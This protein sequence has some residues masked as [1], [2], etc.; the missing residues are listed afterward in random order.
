MS[1]LQDSAAKVE[2]WITERERSDTNPVD[3]RRKT[4]QGELKSPKFVKFH[5]LDS[6]EGC[7]EIFWEDPR[8]FIPRRGRNDWIDSWGI[9]PHDRR[10]AR[11]VDGM[12]IFE[13]THV[14]QLIYRDEDKL[15]L[16]E[17]QFINVLIDKKVSQLKQA[18]L[19]DLPQ[20]DYTLY[21]SLPFIDDPHDNKVDRYWRRVR[22]SGGLPLS[23]FADKIITPLWGWMRNLHA[24][25]F[26]DFKDGALFGPKDCN[27]VDMMHLDKSGYK[28]IPEDE[29]SIAYILRSPGDVMGYHYD[30]GDNWFV[31]IKLEEIASKEDSTGAVVV[32][33]GAGGIPPDGEQT[34]TFS[35]AH[36]LQQASRSPAG[37]RKAVEVLFGTANYAK[38]LPPS[39]ALTYDFDAF[40]LDGTRRAVREALD[41][42]A[43]LPYASKK[44]VTPLGDRTLESMLDDEAVLS[45]LGMSLKDLKKGVALAQTPLSGSSRTFMEEG[46]SISR[47]DNPGNTACA[48]CGSPKDLKA[49]AAC[50]QRYYCGKEC[51]R[52]HWKEGHKRECK[53]AKRK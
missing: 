31:D 35:W 2:A 30:F 28:Y 1:F 48:Y 9:Y 21:I 23:V 22:V 6:G 8:D 34:G 43:S 42:K 24:H 17:I 18:D 47:K 5:M 7:D 19:G 4:P 41:S 46:V 13:R 3:P 44:F 14:T 51:Q 20:R 29:Y 39:N 33:D 26:H 12:R 40:D 32:L 11:D 16:P 45:R 10:G 49:C 25:I 15:P 53:S 38:K 50:G 37:K 27:S 36:Y 52:A